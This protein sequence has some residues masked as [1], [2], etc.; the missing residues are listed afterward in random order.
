MVQS[1]G[2]KERNTID[3]H[4]ARV[5]RAEVASDTF[6]HSRRRAHT[7]GRW[8]WAVRRSGSSGA[9][10][11]ARVPPTSPPRLTKSIATRAGSPG[12]TGSA[13]AR[14]A[15]PGNDRIWTSAQ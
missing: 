5:R 12:R 11:L 10:P 15:P 4:G 1:R 14:A 6:G 8:G 2:L 3:G 7:R 13:T 9:R